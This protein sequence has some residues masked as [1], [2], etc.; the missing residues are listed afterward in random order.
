MPSIIEKTLLSMTTSY[1]KLNTV[2]QCER[3][4]VILTYICLLVTWDGLDVSLHYQTEF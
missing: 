1:N 4:K 2:F 3:I